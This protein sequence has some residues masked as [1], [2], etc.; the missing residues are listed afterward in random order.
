[1]NLET[2]IGFVI[3]GVAILII[4]G[5]VLYFTVF[6]KNA[7]PPPPSPPPVFKIE[8]CQ[9]NQISVN[10]Y[11]GTESPNSDKQYTYYSKDRK[12]IMRPTSEDG[13]GWDICSNVSGEPTFKCES[14]SRIAFIPINKSRPG[15]P[16]TQVT[17]WTSSGQTK[18]TLTYITS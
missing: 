11:K 14:N 3:L 5:I 4:I 13:S 15:M 2:K 10:W 8:S 7:P 17:I 1:M 18:C 6:K 16:D 12:L 9:N